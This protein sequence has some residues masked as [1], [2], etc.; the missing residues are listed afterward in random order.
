MKQF[1]KRVEEILCSANKQVRAVVVL[2]ALSALAIQPAYSQVEV[3]V[4]FDDG[5]IG[6]IGNNSNTATNIQRFAT[7]SIAKM[8]FVQTTNSGRFELTQGNDI[9]GI[10]RLQL[11][12]GNKIDISGKVN[13]RENVG[14]TNVVLGFLADSNVSL[15]LSSSGGPNYAIRG[16][17][18]SGKSNFGFKL[19]SVTYSL[20]ATGGSL[21]GNAATGTSALA[22]LNAYLDALPRVVSPIPANFPL[23]SSNQDPGDFSLVNFPS[24]TLL[25]SV[26]LVN[27]PAGV[28]FSINTTTGLTLSTGY[29][30][31][32]GL[33]RISFTGTQA[34][35][36]DA[37]ANIRVNTGSSAGDVKISVSATVNDNTVTFNPVNGHFYKAVFS[38]GIS[39]A[40]AKSGAAAQTYKGAAGYL[41]TITSAIEQDFVNLQTTQDNI[42]IALSDVT[43]E[44]TWAIDAGPE[45]G[46]VIWR[47]SVSGI[48]N[49]TN[50]TYSSSGTAQGGFYSN[51][52]GSEPNNADGSIG[53]DY[54]VTK[55]TGGTCW[56]DLAGSSTS[57]R[58]YLVEF[59]TW[60]DPD[61]NAFLDFYTASTTYVATCTTGRPSVPTVVTQGTSEGAG[62]VLLVVSVPSGVTVDWYSSATGGS[63]LSGGTGVTTFVTPFISS[64]TTYYAQARN[65]T[66]GCVSATRTA[67][68]ATI[69]PCTTNIDI[70]TI[71]NQIVCAGSATT[72]INFSPPNNSGYQWMTISSSSGTSAAGTGQNG[73]TVSISQPG[74]GLG[75][76]P[77]MYASNRFPATYNVP[78]TGNQIKNTRSGVFTATFS[79]PVTNPLVAFASVGN[80]SNPVPVIVSS[81]FTPIWTDNATSG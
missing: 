81:P 61:D 74:G 76:E 58:G 52:C 75:I 40:N 50:S 17:D 72:G 3:S 15:N 35:I 8:S 77:G 48:T 80:P 46:R 21:S 54:A 42:W 12:N 20:P 65:T 66:G 2:V 6:L 43:T 56:N 25:A 73:I 30:S 10:L 39:Y 9:R 41:V 53:E 24:G 13:W 19:N 34:Q 47:T 23:N 55:W 32:T 36:N 49:S 57:A 78:T 64:T 68:T 45:Q 7:L 69:T 22:D 63:V 70:A 71:S 31:W 60:T 14:N 33:T 67:V 62:T 28:T 1:L 29:T 38:S 4:P 11:T 79:Q 44:G 18:T 5:F 51:W 37:L 27:P 59:G 26:G 16:G